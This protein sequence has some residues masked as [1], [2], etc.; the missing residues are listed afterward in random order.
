MSESKRRHVTRHPVLL[1]DSDCV[2]CTR[3]VRL[4]LRLDRCRRLRFAPLR[5]LTASRL[6]RSGVRL[7]MAVDAVVLVEPRGRV[8]VGSDAVL[9]VCRHLPWPW[10]ALEILTVV[11][12]VIRA[13]VYEW[14]A[15]HRYRWFGRQQQCLLP[16]QT[17]D[18]LLP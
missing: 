15:R 16:G 5:G 12:G 6:R 3:S 13:P 1:F 14:V 7:P 4:L 9:R 10:R 8:Y 18:A 17:A 11:P 2:L